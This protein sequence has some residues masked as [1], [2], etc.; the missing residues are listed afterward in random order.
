V[1]CDLAVGLGSDDDLRGQGSH[2]GPH[3]LR[4]LGYGLAGALSLPLVDFESGHFFG[5]HVAPFG[6]ALFTALALSLGLLLPDVLLELL[7]D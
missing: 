3:P 1:I 7:L 5:L 2:L 4:P 6:L